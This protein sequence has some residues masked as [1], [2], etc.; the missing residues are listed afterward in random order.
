MKKI[1]LAGILAGILAF[2]FYQL[3]PV[4]YKINVY[5]N[6][7]TA[8]CHSGIRWLGDPACVKDREVPYTLEKQQ[9]RIYAWWNRL[10]INR[11][12]PKHVVTTEDLK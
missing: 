7:F 10:E 5:E 3:S 4:G 8:R 2:V 1:L 9:P 11:I 12:F 6:E